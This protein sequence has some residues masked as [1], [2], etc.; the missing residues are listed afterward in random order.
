MMY[1]FTISNNILFDFIRVFFFRIQRIPR[2]IYSNSSA[3]TQ[4]LRV[5]FRSNLKNGSW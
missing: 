5:M 1:V 3:N 2:N 4:L